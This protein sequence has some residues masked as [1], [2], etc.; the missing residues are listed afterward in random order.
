MVENER[1]CGGKTMTGQLT[2]LIMF[3]AIYSFFFFS[4][5]GGGGRGRG[6]C[7]DTE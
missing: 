2:T 7:V 6:V 3:S 5:G 4:G 1:R